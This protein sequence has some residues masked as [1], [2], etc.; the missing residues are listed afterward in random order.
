MTRPFPTL[1][2]TDLYST[3]PGHINV[4]HSDSKGVLPTAAS[5]V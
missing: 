2:L 1:W 4:H 5:E 3:V